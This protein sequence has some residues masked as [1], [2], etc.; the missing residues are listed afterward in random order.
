V[1]GS[2]WSV[3]YE[4]AVRDDGTL[5]F[6]ERLTKEFLEQARR[7]MGSY[8]FANQYQNEVI[9]EDEKRFKAQWLRYYRT[10]PSNTHRFAFVD[11]AIGQRER[12]DY[13]GITVI[14]V[15]SDG[16][17]Y[18]RVAHR[19]RL[20][21]TQIVDKIF[22]IQ[23]ELSCQAIG[24]E[25]VAY[26][27]ALLY[28]L[29]EKMRERKTMLPVKGIRRTAISKETRILGLVPRF[30]W[31]GISLAQGLT[32]FE[33]EYNSFPRGSHDDI[34]DSLA[35]LEEIVFYP[36]KEEKKLEKPANP[37]DPRY[38]QWVIQQLH[39]RQGSDDAD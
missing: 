13:T 15:D 36:Q 29:S 17:W 25:I 7:T 1:S 8:L 6:P 19:A 33:D 22:H 30:E 16:H 28:I 26:Q 3:V 9:P 23:K 39:R 2:Q 34:L 32:D 24:V 27:E 14:D 11:P 35:S 5:L 31:G 21:P 4:R 12:N 37:N 20:T 18:L 38:E 10:I